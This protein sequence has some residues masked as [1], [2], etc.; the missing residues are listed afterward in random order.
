MKRIFT[1][2]LSVAAISTLATSC[3]VIDEAADTL[4]FG[5]NTEYVG[6]LVVSSYGLDVYNPEE[7][8]TFQV[9]VE[10]DSSV[11]IIMAE[12]KFN[13]N[14]PAMTITLG[15]MDFDGTNISCDALTP[16]LAGAP[17]EAYPITDVVG[18]V[19]AATLNIEF[20][21]TAYIEATETYIPSTI[22]FSGTVVE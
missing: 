19:D 18:T 4:G 17:L 11:S 14:M 15:D 1:M 6:K 5:D 3:D 22:S 13:E 10:S 16:T 9:D 8:F 2:L 7:A 12:V 21:Y 20:V